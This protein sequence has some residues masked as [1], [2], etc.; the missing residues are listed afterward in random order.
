LFKTCLLSRVLRFLAFAGGDLRLQTQNRI[1]PPLDMRLC[2]LS[3]SLQAA[4]LHVN[5]DSDRNTTSNSA[6]GRSEMA[7][8]L[9]HM[10]VKPGAEA[11]FERLARSLYAAS[12]GHEP[13]MLRY[14]YW[15]GEAAGTYYCLQ[16]FD[17]YRAFLEHETAPHHEAAAEPI[18]AL[19]EHFRLEWVDPVTDA[20]PLASSLAEP[21]P[22]NADER[23]R[24]YA[25]LF[26][27]IERTW[28]RDQA[29]AETGQ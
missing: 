11:A 6:K 8:C 28:W 23:T 20:A 1:A 19:I 17:R 25:G 16:S 21:L 9:V 29:F 27:L 10:R 12:T 26:P 5:A 3:P 2:H 24:F 14:E 7:T 15:R 22:L 18:M 4:L 13:G